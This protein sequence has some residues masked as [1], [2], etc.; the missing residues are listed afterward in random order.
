MAATGWLPT[1]RVSVPRPDDGGLPAGI[2][3]LWS[4]FVDRV[5][6]DEGWIALPLVLILAGTMA[7]SIADARWILGNDSL[8]TFLIPIALVA[9]AWGYLSAR[10]DV[11]PWLAQTLGCVIGAFVLIEAVGASLPGSTPTLDGWF[12]ATANSVAQAYLD[13]AWRHQVSTLQVGHFGLILGIIVWGTA[14][15]ASYDIFG[16]HRGVNGVLL[17]AV[18]LIANMAL[19]VHDQYGGLVVF[20]VAALAVLLVT[21][22]ADERS[23]WLR[24]RIWRGRDFQ[25][26]H[27]QGGVAFA[28]LVVAGSLV[29]TSVASSAPLASTFHDLGAHLQDYFGWMSGYLPNGGQSRYQ[30]TS[31]FGPSVDMKPSFNIAP[32][33]VFTARLVAGVGV[34]H[35]R[36][37]AY[38]E[39]RTTG[40]K[41]GAPTSTDQIPAGATLDDKT[42]DL[43][44]GTTPGRAL[45]TVLIHVQ[46]PSLGQLVVPNEPDSVNTGTERTVVGGDPA[47][48]NLAWLSTDA[49]DYT[50][51]A[52]V[53]DYDP[54]GNGLTEWRLQHAGSDFPPALLTRY[55]QGVPLVGADGNALL[56]EIQAWAKSNGNTFGNEYDVAK[57]VQDYLRSDRFTYTTDITSAMPRCLG[58]STVD[59][60]AYI[61]E[62]FCE[63]YASTM[64][65]LMRMAGYPARYVEG[66]L[67]GA[68][69]KNTQVEQVTSDRRHAWV[70]VYF[71]TYGWIPFDPT[72]GG[73]GVPTTLVKGSE[74]APNPSPASPVPDERNGGV[75]PHGDTPTPGGGAT[76]GGANNYLVLIPALLFGVIALAI[77]V[78][79]WRRPRRLEEPDSVYRNVVRLASQLGYKP[80]PTQ[81]VYEYTGM[82]ADVVPKARDSLGVVAMATVEVTYGRRQ[83]AS[84]RLVSLSTAQRIIRGALLR[85]LIRIP[86]FGRG[87]KPAGAAERRSGR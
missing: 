11:S 84:E 36:V 81:T 74:L 87:A 26:P 58:L 15:A 65:M 22:A 72:G 43:V 34:S 39:F 53:P 16:Y 17:M 82:L 27:L 67:P 49:T 80:H 25:A 18:V 79:W 9:A 6:P 62:G 52:L 51:E 37:I 33:D 66:Y 63:Q 86:R 31:D 47:A 20:S 48:T 69:D 42:L 85:L 13:L 24:H 55:T 56:A 10:L 12:N 77:F 44:T 7:W 60:F 1:D 46:D 30:P 54:A 38:D 68:I 73:V 76:T 21:H 45:I 28:A 5:R 75:K 29:L 78:L 71:P 4:R 35:W 41:V 59:C 14:Q 40:W 50:V 83:L 70:E 19:T 57:A 23:N 61:R 8:T 3:G 2:G 32:R 64:T